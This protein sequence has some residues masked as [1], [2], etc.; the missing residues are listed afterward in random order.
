MNKALTP[1]HSRDFKSIILEDV[2][3]SVT[4]LE[5]QLAARQSLRN[6]RRL[7]PFFEV[8]QRF[9]KSAESLCSGTPYLQLAWAPIAEILRA[10]SAF[11]DAFD[12]II[13]GYSELASSLLAFQR[14]GATFKDDAIFQDT[15]AV[16]Y[17]NILEFHKYAYT[18]VHKSGMMPCSSLA[19]CLP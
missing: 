14:L 7:L 17:A 11:V 18:C 12:K 8:L 2:W 19:V 1:V 16:I 15:L 13:R 4:A 5:E 9:S 3:K 10:S 6:M